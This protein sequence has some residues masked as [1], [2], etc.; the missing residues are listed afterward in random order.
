MLS[1][2]AC[3]SWKNDPM[4]RGGTSFIKALPGEDREDVEALRASLARATPPLFWAGEA[5][6]AKTHPWTVHGA[7]ATGIRVA[8]QVA[9]YL[10]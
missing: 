10:G 2:Y 1:Y 9:R 4:A 5:T 6:A 7:H 3:K 8:R